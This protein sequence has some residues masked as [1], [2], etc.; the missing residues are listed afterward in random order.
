MPCKCKNPAANPKRTETICLT[1][2]SAV[3]IYPGVA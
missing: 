1:K 3:L 2:N